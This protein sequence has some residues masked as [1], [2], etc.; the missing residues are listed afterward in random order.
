MR[1][2]FRAANMSIGHKL[3]IDLDSVEPGLRSSTIGVGTQL[4][5]LSWLGVV[6]GFSSSMEGR[7]L[8]ANMEGSFQGGY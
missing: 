6:R 8:S 2:E 1:Y 5:Y 3:S 7:G 4:R